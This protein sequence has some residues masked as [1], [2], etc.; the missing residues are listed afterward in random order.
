MHPLKVF[1]GILH[2]IFCTH[3]NAVHSSN[4]P[5]PS[6]VTLLKSMHSSFLHPAKTPLGISVIS[7]GSSVSAVPASERLFKLVT[8]VIDSRLEHPSNMLFDKSL[9]GPKSIFSS[10]VQLLN[11]LSPKLVTLLKPTTLVSD[12]HPSKTDSSKTTSP[13]SNTTLFRFVTPENVLLPKFTF[14]A[15]TF[16]VSLSSD[17]FPVLESNEPSFNP[18]LAFF[19][20]IVSSSLNPLN[21]KPPVFALMLSVFKLDFSELNAPSGIVFSA[22]S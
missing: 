17:F 2:P 9:P 15:S 4:A 20:L 22:A 19:I 8:P 1:S 11:R 18:W 10:P 12:V 21:E 7:L 3:F 16:N 5:A 14:V 6:E 13:C